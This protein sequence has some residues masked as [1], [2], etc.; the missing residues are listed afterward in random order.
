M[1]R[2]LIPILVIIFVLGAIIASAGPIRFDVA[3]LSKMT[4]SVADLMTA[5]TDEGAFAATLLGYA[6]AAALLTALNI[7]AANIEIDASPAADD[8][9][10]SIAINGQ[11]AGEVTA[12]W[13]AVYFDLTDSEYKLA[14]ND[15]AGEWPVVG[16]GIAIG[17][18]GAELKIVDHGAIRNDGWA[19]G[20]STYGQPIYLDSTAGGLTTTRPTS[21]SSIVQE[22]G[23]VISDDEIFVN[24]KA[25]DWG[26]TRYGT[27]ADNIVLTCTEA[28]NT[29]WTVTVADK[30][31]I[32]P[33]VATCLTINTTVITVGAIA[34]DV[35]VNDADRMIYI[36]G[37]E[38]IEGHKATNL[39]TAGDQISCV[40]ASAV[41][42]VC[43]SNGWTQE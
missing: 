13:D 37:A 24:I 39:S 8:T 19:W 12:Q 38:N 6:D 10:K 36:D 43:Q 5:L 17:A 20:A 35:D 33:G 18:D 23:W 42:V 3:E 16:L 22:I 27:T 14:D 34:V 11:N 26:T 25:V 40:Y 31:V 21:A 7:T 9:Y 4:G 28:S 1:K 29:V 2:T 41:G 15:V 32:L 30:D